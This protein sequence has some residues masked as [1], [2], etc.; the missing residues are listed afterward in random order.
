MKLCPACAATIEFSITVKSPL[1]GFSYRPEYP[2][3]SLSVCAA[4][5][6]RSGRQLLHK[7]EYR[8]GSFCFRIEHLIGTCKTIVLNNT[9]MHLADCDDPSIKIRRFIRDRLMEHS[10]I[11][12]PC[13]TRF[14]CV[15]TRN[16]HQF[17]FHLLIHSRKATY[18]LTHCIFIVRRTRT[19]Q[20]DEF[21]RFSCKIALISSSLFLLMLSVSPPLGTL[22]QCF[23]AA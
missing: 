21:I 15:N 8:P 2:F 14:I 12:L 7:R 17:I 5:L 9:E 6:P 18:I 1:V 3:H 22:F 19:D 11:P 16:D 13:C 4:G 23:R 10:F 20:Y